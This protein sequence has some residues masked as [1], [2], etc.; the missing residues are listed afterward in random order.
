MNSETVR[1]QVEGTMFL[2]MSS[3]LRVNT[4]RNYLHLVGNTSKLVLGA[5]QITELMLLNRALGL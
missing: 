2:L 4:S 3:T 1:S 5:G